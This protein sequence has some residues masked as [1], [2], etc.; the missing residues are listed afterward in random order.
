MS[1]LVADVFAADG[2]LARRLSGFEERPQQREMAAAVAQALERGQHLLCEAGTGV[3]KS[4]AYLVPAILY[5]ARTK[6][7]VVVSTWTIALQE[8]LV[9]RDLP[10]LREA[11]GVPFRFALLKGRNQYVGLRRL[12]HAARRQQT[13]L[14]GAEQRDQ[15][16]RIQAWARTTADGSRSDLDFQPSPAVW[17]SVLSDSNNCL[18]R[19]CEHF[20]Q[21]FYQRARRAAERADLLVVNH[22]LFFSDLALR[23]GGARLLPDYDAVIF[24]EAHMLDAAAAEHFGLSLSQA[25]IRYLLS[26][27]WNPRTKRGMLRVLPDSGV[28]DLVE[29]VR[30]LAE[31]QFEALRRWREEAVSRNG[32][33]VGP[34]PVPDDL[35]PA[36]RDLAR[37]LRGVRDEFRGD[38]EHEIGA[39]A[40][41]A[42]ECAAL[43]AELL[44]CDDPERVYWME[45]GS[46][47]LTLHAAP[48]EVAPMLRESLFATVR[49]AVLTS[50]TLAT[51]GEDPFAFIRARTGIGDAPAVKL[52][53]PFD[54][55]MQVRLI[56]DRRLPEPA[57]SQAYYDRLA[58]A[59]AE[60]V[61][62][63]QGR[64]FVLFTSYASL[65][66]VAE[67]LGDRLGA[68]GYTVLV[69][70]RDL[71]RTQMLDAFRSAPRGVIFGVDSF[72]QGVDV[73]GEALSNVIITRLPFAVP[74]RPLLEARLE[75]IR[76]EGGDPF[77]EYQLP[78]A[79]LRF[80]QGFGRLIRSRTDTGLVVV[81]DPRVLTRSYGRWFLEAIPPCATEVRTAQGL[82]PVADETLGW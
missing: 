63:T 4:F 65:N 2:P 35:S 58:E 80:K 71:S 5:T 13:L 64:A 55:R 50:A 60:Y 6:A 75:R 67:R 54:Y 34:P 27:L 42:D 79:V 49:T 16:A 15:I 29:R 3:G 81:L 56:L 74:D 57:D 28:R 30:G 70:G 36:L 61:A 73:K 12:A 51:G 45:T 43:L 21:C 20:R 52:G 17:Q 78:E 24:D 1:D 32:R 41:R 44:R 53:C 11:L 62:W 68:D 22:A 9:Q 37:A 33:L 19:N 14:V 48:V 23:Q 69:Q 40:T 18:G 76:Q 47:G 39:L 31:G 7:R 59:V 26:R 66:A 38:D 77:R 82:V 8:Q 72:W 46:D 10:F 25:Q